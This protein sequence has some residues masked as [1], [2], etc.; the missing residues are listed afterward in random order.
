MTRIIRKTA[1]RLCTRPVL[2]LVTAATLLVVAARLLALQAPVTPSTG[3]SRSAQEGRQVALRDQLRVG[4]KARTKADL[5]FIELVVQ[6]VDQGV[7]PRPLVDSTFLWAR[8]RW[9]TRPGS[10]RL[11]PIV[12]FQPAL[13]LRARQ[14][15]ISL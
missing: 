7:L 9:R 13:T 5:Q 12:Y 6:R 3:G 1:F 11:R 10:H 15:G 14:L 2:S 4:L 8:N